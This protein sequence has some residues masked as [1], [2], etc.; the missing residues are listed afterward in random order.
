MHTHIQTRVYACYPS[1]PH[2]RVSVHVDVWAHTCEH[3][4]HLEDTGS[5]ISAAAGLSLSRCTAPDAEPAGFSP[6]SVPVSTL[7]PQPS[8]DRLPPGAITISLK[9][10]LDMDRRT[11]RRLSATTGFVPFGSQEQGTARGRRTSVPVLQAS[12]VSCPGASH[13]LKPK[14]ASPG[15]QQ[16]SSDPV[17]TPAELHHSSPTG[18]ASL[19]LQESLLT[20]CFWGPALCFTWRIKEITFIPPDGMKVIR[21]TKCNFALQDLLERN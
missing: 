14:R 15:E 12:T 17:P 9:Q 4:T 13:F 6:P 19:L 7:L 11:F 3:E 10:G 20:Y 2:M 21:N 16:D 1:V 5:G 8:E 18:S